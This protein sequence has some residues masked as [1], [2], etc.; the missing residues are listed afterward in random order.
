MFYGL[1]GLS[2]TLADYILA[3]GV[4]FEPTGDLRRRRFSRPV[5]STT[6]PP[7]QPL[8]LFESFPVFHSQNFRLC[9]RVCDRPVPRYHLRPTR[10]SRRGFNQPIIM[11]W[12]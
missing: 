2:W 9:G 8:N 4:G 6:Q 3:E 1:V 7:L 10:Q 12:M 11:F 5:L